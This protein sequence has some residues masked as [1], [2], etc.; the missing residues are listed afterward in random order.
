MP[1]KETIGADHPEIAVSILDRHS[2]QVAKGNRADEENRTTLDKVTSENSIVADYVWIYSSP[3]FVILKISIY[4]LSDTPPLP[5]RLKCERPP[6]TE[7]HEPAIDSKA[8]S[9]PHLYIPA[10]H[11]A[12]LMPI[13]HADPTLPPQR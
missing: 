10:Q 7:T 9:T 6:E 11:S 3:P 4:L 8:Y 13:T 2:P 1:K 12:T 5:K